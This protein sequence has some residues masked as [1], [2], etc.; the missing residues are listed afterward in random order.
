MRYRYF[1]FSTLTPI[2]M[3]GA[4]VELRAQLLEALRALR[5]HLE[6]V[7]VRPRRI[8]SKTRW[9]YA[10][11]TSIVEQIAHGVHEDPLRRLPCERQLQHVR[12]QRQL[13]PVA[14]VRLPHRL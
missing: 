8:T 3:F 2:Q 1:S 13:E 9:M 14:V 5:Q 4:H 12:L 10:S 11:G 6:L 7:P